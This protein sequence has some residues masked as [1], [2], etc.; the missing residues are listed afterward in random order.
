[1]NSEL[2]LNKNWCNQIA[3]ILHGTGKLFFGIA[4][5]LGVYKADKVVKNFS[6][7]QQQSQQQCQTTN[8][9]Y[10]LN[11]KEKQAVNEILNKIENKEPATFDTAIAAFAKENA[12][13]VDGIKFLPMFEP[14]IVDDLKSSKT[15]QEMGEVLEKYIIKSKEFN[16][17]I[18]QFEK[19]QK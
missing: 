17:N 6:L 10:Y 15:R 8:N 12:N 9:N 16:N 1:M 19:D 3:P 13:E 4:A 18:K 7:S 14:M 2:N 5:I 11:A